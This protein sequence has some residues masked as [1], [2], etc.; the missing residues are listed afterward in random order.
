M[1]TNPLATQR[2]ERAR[3]RG[4]A[5][6]T[7]A[8]VQK[9]KAAVF[10]ACLLPLLWLTVKMLWLGLGANP[11]EKMIRFIGDWA[12]YLLLITLAMTP[13]KRWFK[14]PWPLKIRRMLGLFSFFYVCLHVIGYV[15]IDQFFDWSEIWHDIVKRPFITLGFACLLT[16]LPLAIT[17]SNATQRRL[18]RRWQQ[19]HYL[20]Y[21]LAIGAVTHYWWMVKKDI[22]QPAICAVLLALLL[23]LRLYWAGRRAQ[24]FNVG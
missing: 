5:A 19:L 7:P 11:I 15:V 24:Y 9:I 8:S 6:T 2:G 17:S 12:L 3:E 14:W 4:A 1:G 22:T 23:G 20:V 18:G 10:I 13:L 21:P 16:I